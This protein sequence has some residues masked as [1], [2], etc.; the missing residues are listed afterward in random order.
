MC[1]HIAVPDQRAEIKEKYI[2]SGPL[3]MSLADQ[4]M[5]P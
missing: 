3:I 5:S 2:A 4:I 1:W